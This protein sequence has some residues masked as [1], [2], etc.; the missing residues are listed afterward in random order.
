MELVI[1]GHH[2]MLRF[3]IGITCNFLVAVAFSHLHM[4]MAKGPPP[5]FKLT[6]EVSAADT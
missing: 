3:Y 4:Q 6:K 5:S 1:D 2:S